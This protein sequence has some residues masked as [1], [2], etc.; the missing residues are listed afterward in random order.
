MHF[1]RLTSL[2]YYRWSSIIIAWHVDYEKCSFESFISRESRELSSASPN[3]FAYSA[4]HSSN[5]I[6]QT[7][8]S[9]TQ[10][11]TR[12]PFATPLQ[13]L[14]ASFN[15]DGFF[16]ELRLFGSK[17]S[18]HSFRLTD[19]VSSPDYEETREADS[20]MVFKNKTFTYYHYFLACSAPTRNHR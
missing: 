16:D 10:E 7:S 11:N 13:P 17:E 6:V 5:F 4:T 3:Q 2:V 19:D 20:F 15:S 1:S 9:S 8:Y 14:D 12:E 18:L